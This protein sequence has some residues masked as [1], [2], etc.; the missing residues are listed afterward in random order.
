MAY[1]IRFFHAASY[2][3]KIGAVRLKI[4]A[5]RLTP[6]KGVS[7]TALVYKLIILQLKYKQTAVFHPK[8]GLPNL[9]TSSR[10]EN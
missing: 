5:V 10:F 9:S 1:P 2:S 8:S 6:I 7:R 4:G 3:L